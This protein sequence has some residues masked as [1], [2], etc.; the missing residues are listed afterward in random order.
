MKNL[1]NNLKMFLW[2][3]FL[4]GIAYPLLIT[5][6]AQLTMQRQAEG[7]LII[8]KGTVVGASLIGQKFQ[9]EKYF[10]GR[11]SAVDY[12]PLPSGA[13]NLGP[14]SNVLKKAVQERKAIIE[15]WPGVNDKT[16]IPSELLFASGSGLDPHITP[17]A[18]YF[19]MDRIIKSRGWEEKRFKDDLKKLIDKHIEKRTFGFLGDPYINV[20]KLNIALDEMKLK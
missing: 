20:L 16:Q 11:P 10:W 3:A 7:D 17:T 8:S 18:A 6:I 9:N 2:M 14:I 1:W 4:T 5:G 15:K 12:N 13:S 19:Q